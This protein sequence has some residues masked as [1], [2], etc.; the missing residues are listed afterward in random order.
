M[1]Y[2][3]RVKIGISVIGMG[4]LFCTVLF[5]FYRQE[6]ELPHHI[7][8][9]QQLEKGRFRFT[10]YDLKNRPVDLSAFYGKYLAINF[11]ATWCVPCVVELPS[12]MQ[13][14]ET[15]GGKL[16]ILAVSNEDLPEIKT[17]FKSFRPLSPYFIPVRMSRPDM[18]S[19]FQV[20]AFPET[21]LL[22]KKGRLIRKI[23]GPQK[24]DSIEWTEYMQ[25]LL[26]KE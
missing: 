21:Y 5:Y 2:F 15:F 4:L 10:A 13:L 20:E 25:S 6:E 18:L 9:N 3:Q 7:Q 22:D 14:A 24:W 8:K 26:K 16:V 11:W 19:A 1:S 12:L 17:F 23:I